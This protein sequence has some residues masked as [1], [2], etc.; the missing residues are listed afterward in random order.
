MPHAASL[1]DSEWLDI[2][3]RLPPDLDL[4][5]LARETQAIVRRREIKDGGDL[6]RLGLA[7]GP[8]G[9]SLPQTAAW[10]RL[11][12][13]CELSAP[14]L[15]DRLHQ[16]VAFFAAIVRRLLAARAPAAS[17]PWHGR[18]LRLHDSSSLSQ[19]GSKGINWRIHAVYDLGSASFSSLE[20]TDAQ[21][22][23][24]LTYGTVEE[25]TIAIADR[26]YAHA[27]DMAAFLRPYG[28]RI[29]DFIVRVGWNSLRLENNDGSPFDLVAILTEMSED[30]AVPD[31]PTPREWTGQ[32]LYGR[33][34]QIRKLPIR[35]AIL[36]LPRDKVEIARKK[37][38]RIATKQQSKL[39][40]KTLLAAGFLILATSL[41]AQFAAADICAV[42]RL[43]WQIELA[44]KRLKSL[45]KVDLLPT[46]TE[47]GGRSWIYPHL[48]LALLTE[49]ICQEI[50]ESSPS[51]PC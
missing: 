47:A 25:G 38:R 36:A 45:I 29:G 3:D 5:Q 16:S 7:H 42:Y 46:R 43:R 44:F 37:I 50:L 20:L 27:N 19:P 6:L 30:P 34:K 8:G 28:D 12:G 33:G 35:L 49:E 2:L 41:S 4:D 48:I 26:G 23:E 32:A 10:A 18:C 51:G 15:S 40:P 13:I 39:N 9:M 17:S 11:S 31:N 14:S 1:F 21:G 22:A 24:S